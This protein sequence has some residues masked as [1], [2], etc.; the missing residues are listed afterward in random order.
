MI[1]IRKGR[2]KGG[3]VGEKGKAWKLLRG[4]TIEKGAR[5]KAEREGF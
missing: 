4:G 2:G 3:K 5:G 1:R